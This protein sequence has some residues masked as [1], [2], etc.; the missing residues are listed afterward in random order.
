MHD[1]QYPHPRQ[2]FGIIN[3]TENYDQE[4]THGLNTQGKNHQG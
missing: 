4:C 1:C 2:T 3:A